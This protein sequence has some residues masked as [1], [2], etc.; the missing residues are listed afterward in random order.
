MHRIM[1]SLFLA[2][3]GRSLLVVLASLG[4]I[5]ETSDGTSMLLCRF[6]C[7]IEVCP[8][9]KPQPNQRDCCAGEHEDD[10]GST[11][12]RGGTEDCP[13]A[14]SPERT[15]DGPPA[16]SSASPVTESVLQ[17]ICVPERT[18][19]CVLR[20]GETSAGTGASPPPGAFAPT[21]FGTSGRMAYGGLW[22]T[23]VLGCA[24]I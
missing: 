17:W 12:G 15:S 7:G 3:V 21:G 1:T 5:L 16:T 6:L 14:E 9:S 22:S 10:D 23:S 2:R 11:C 8:L 4:L 13:C 18:V 24:R 19:F 20:V